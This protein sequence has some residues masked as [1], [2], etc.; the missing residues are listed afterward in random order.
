ME[1]EV[2]AVIRMFPVVVARMELLAVVQIREWCQE[3]F[4]ERVISQPSFTLAPG[5]EETQ[6]MVPQVAL[7]VERLRSQRRMSFLPQARRL[8]RVAEAQ[9]TGPEALALAVRS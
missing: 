8:Q 3:K 1:V 5:E 2:V 9:E 6:L 7:E 4:T